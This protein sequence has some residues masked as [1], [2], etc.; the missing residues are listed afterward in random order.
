LRYRSLAKNTAQL[1]TL[2]ALAGLTTPGLRLDPTNRSGEPQLNPD[3]CYPDRE[4]TARR[5]RKLRL[6]RQTASYPPG[7]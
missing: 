5:S 7:V 6:S 3:F 2:F 1:H 4:P